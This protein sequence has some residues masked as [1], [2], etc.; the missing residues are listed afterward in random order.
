M[1]AWLQRKRKGTVIDWGIFLRGVGDPQFLIRNHALLC[2]NTPKLFVCCLQV[3]SKAITLRQATVVSR[4]TMEPLCSR[5]NLGTFPDSGHLFNRVTM[6]GDTTTYY[7]SPLVV[8]DCAAVVSCFM[9]GTR[10]RVGCSC[11]LPRFLL[12]VQLAPAA[13]TAFTCCSNQTMHP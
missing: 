6:S 2:I 10:G 1:M 5:V 9:K 11:C 12:G 8:L 7:I 13:P 4:G 3:G